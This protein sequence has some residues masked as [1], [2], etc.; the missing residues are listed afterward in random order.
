MLLGELR[1]M[2]LGIPGGAGLFSQL[3]LA[4]VR[5]DGH[6]V[7]LHA[8]ALDQLEDFHTLAMDVAA[9]PTHIA[10]I[11]P[12]T[13]AFIGACD[14]AKSGMGGVWLPPDRPSH[15]EPAHPPIV[16]RAPFPIAIQQALVSFENP[17]GTITNSDLELAGTIGNADVLVHAVDCRHRTIATMCD[18][19][20]AVSWQKKRSVTTAGAASYLLREASLHQRWAGS[21]TSISCARAST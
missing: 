11:I 5:K 20:P 9:R 8:Q 15:R 14:A 21:A 19:T 6:R 13:P 18:N 4:L 16:W 7:K 1:S 10:E 3:Q 17:T 2:V 12:Q